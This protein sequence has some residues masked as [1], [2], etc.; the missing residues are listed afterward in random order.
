MKKLIFLGLFFP[1]ILFLNSCRQND[2]ITDREILFNSGWK[3]IRTDF[4]GAENPEFDDS[5]WR[6]LVLPH[7]YSIE[8]LPEK[9]GVKQIGPF[10]EE[11]EG[12]ISTGHVVGGTAWYRKHFTLNK[13][14][15]GKIVKI[16]FDG[17]Y[18]NDEVIGTKPVSDET[19]LTARFDVPYQPGELVAIGLKNGQETARQILKNA[20]KPAR[21]KLT[22]ERETVS[23][24]Y[25]DLAYFNVEVLDENG[26]LVPYAEIPVEF[27]IEGIGTLQAV[28]NGNPTDMKSF[29]Q[30]RVKT[31][32][33]KCQVIVRS[34]E[35]PGEISVTARSKELE[36]G[37]AQV[38]VLN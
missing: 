27:S 16:L 10:S 6:T 14:D 20:G 32:R 34:S 2:I 4:P 30:P 1:A 33:G 23:A 25:G 21:L 9:E 19:K 31:F 18:M 24:S 35:K 17:V 38:K 28:G 5:A 13:A 36:S 26:L 7:D 8:D 12:G 3:F 37:T 22:A 11:S 15:E 29:Q